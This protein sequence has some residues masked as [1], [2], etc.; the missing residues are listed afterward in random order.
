LESLLIDRA[1]HR[2]GYRLPDLLAE[3][4]MILGLPDVTTPMRR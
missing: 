2:Y 1:M 4:A 3:D